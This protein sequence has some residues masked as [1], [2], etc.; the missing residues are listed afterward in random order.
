VG[1]AHRPRANVVT[2]DYGRAVE[3]HIID[4][5]E[6]DRQLFALIEVVSSAKHLL[7][8]HHGSR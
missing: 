5:W 1:A 2:A 3:Q 7:I 4:L 6:Q 8:K